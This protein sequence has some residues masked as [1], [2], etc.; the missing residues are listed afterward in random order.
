MFGSRS[1]R[2]RL[3]FRYLVV[4]LICALVLVSFNLAV[5]S[6]KT[7]AFLQHGPA[8]LQFQ[9]GR[10]SLGTGRNMSYV[11]SVQFQKGIVPTW[12]DCQ[13]NPNLTT[14]NRLIDDY[15]LNDETKSGENGRGLTFSGDEKVKVDQLIAKYH[16]N[17]YA[18][19]MIPLN[20]KV[21]DS[22]FS[23]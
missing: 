9:M 13:R 18:S 21:P 8:L 12:R 17:V 5:W 19:D 14:G 10:R 11:D 7:A 22:R 1:L 3:A 16:L 23:G 4:F 20:R 6:D 15:G 2:R